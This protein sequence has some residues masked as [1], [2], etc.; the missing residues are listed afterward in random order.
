MMV[1]RKKRKF[2]FK[3]VSFNSAP[4]RP[5]P[6][7]HQLFVLSIFVLQDSPCLRPVLRDV[8]IAL[9][10]MRTK[11]LVFALHLCV[12]YFLHLSYVSQLSATTGVWVKTGP[13]LSH[14]PAPGQDI[15]LLNLVHPAVPLVGSTAS[16]NMFIHFISSY[17]Y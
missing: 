2:I 9:P 15:V 6:Y 11:R 16:L 7:D 8:P 3:H 13:S 1:K 5:P 14:T 12:F 10:V 4:A 17:F